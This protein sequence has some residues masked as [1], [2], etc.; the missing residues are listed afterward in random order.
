M[1]DKQISELQKATS[2]TGNELLVVSQDGKAKSVTVDE[3]G[4]MMPGGGSPDAVLYTPQTLTDAQKAQARKNIGAA[5]VDE[6]VAAL[7]VYAGE[8]EDV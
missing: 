2:L 1:A 3:L 6:V 8:V 4:E 7:P 5:T